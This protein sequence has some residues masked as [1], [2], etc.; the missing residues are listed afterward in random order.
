M[1]LGPSEHDQNPQETLDAAVLDQGP[2]PAAMRYRCICG[3]D[4]EIT[5][6]TASGQTASGP[7][8]C[9]QCGHRLPKSLGHDPTLTLSFC[10]L[11]LDATTD[12]QPGSLQPVT[13]AFTPV[14]AKPPK[15]ATP[16]KHANPT[17]PTRLNQSLRTGERLGHFVLQEPLGQGGMGAVYRALDTSLQRFV[18]VK[19]LR[20]GGEGSSGTTAK[21]TDRL[22]QEAVSQA[23]LNHPRVVTI[24]YVGREGEE[25]FLAMELLP[26]PTLQERLA[27]GPLPYDELIEYAMQV[28]DALEAAD[29]SGMVHGDIK[30]SNLL[31][32]GSRS[33]KLSDFGLARRSGDSSSD[34]SVSGTPN[35][36]APELLDGQAPNVRTDMY[37]L[38]VTLFELA[39]GRRP[40]ELSG[41]TL[42]Q[43]LLTHR[44]AEIQFPQK[45]PSEIPE[46]FR[47][48]LE[49]LL[50]KEPEK[51]FGSYAELRAELRTVCP[52]GSTLAGIPARV[53]AWVADHAAIGLILAPFGILL[54]IV[55]SIIVSELEN[56]SGTGVI[57]GLLLIFE[58]VIETVLGSG[59]FLVPL[60]AMW[61]EMKRYRTPGRYLMQIRVVDKYGLPPSRRAVAL[62]SML[63]FSVIW[64]SAL[65][66]LLFYWGFDFLSVMG[67]LLI[68][69][70]ILIDFVPV[71]GS[72][73]RA[74][75]DLIC[76][77]H[78]VLDER[79]VHRR[80]VTVGSGTTIHSY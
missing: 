46:P 70:W 24:Y 56:G 9:P 6:K 4:I 5:E 55:N 57:P 8:T 15:S 32:A 18:A 48:V 80:S 21:H 16:T 17:N 35:Y 60:A 29:Q 28:T 67:L 75:H 44:T 49:R 23:R 12:L 71:V 13:N 25:P 45:W 11:P 43:Q 2:S 52:I 54:T 47:E 19:V 40:F 69:I 37:A 10:S 62:R 22:R 34:G 33:I 68:P 36:I 78:V 27:D 76:G 38:G 7:Q 61:W 51:R 41:D 1:N 39:F 65:L 30:P 20:T 64:A 73:K 66:G 14:R 72:Q 59:C 31:M 3:H 79:S 53:I 77:T 26:G 50:A 42:R 74:I 63:R 58:G